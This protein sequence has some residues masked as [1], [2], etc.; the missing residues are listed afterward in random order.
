MTPEELDAIE[1]RLNAATSWP[2]WRKADATAVWGGNGASGYEHVAT[3][4]SVRA[5]ADA[6]FLVHAPGDVARLV[7][8]VRRLTRE[9][10][11]ERGEVATLR[12]ILTRG[13]RDEADAALTDAELLRLTRELRSDA[14]HIIVVPNEVPADA[15]RLLELLQPET[16]MEQANE[17]PARPVHPGRWTT[18]WEN[19]RGLVW[20]FLRGSDGVRRARSFPLLD[21]TFGWDIPVVI[22]ETYPTDAT[23]APIWP[24]ESGYTTLQ[25]AQRAAEEWLANN[26]GS[27]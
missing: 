6:G 1:A 10:A 14:S 22:G 27:R 23:G 7:A 12:A 21:G 5:E 20:W 2:W 4:H 13:E 11:E 19:P 3:V 15:E 8:E 16:P 25:D 18:G 17:E 24:G 9:L 26:Q